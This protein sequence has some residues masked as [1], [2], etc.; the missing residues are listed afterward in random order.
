MLLDYY[1]L[2]YG[3][4]YNYYREY[5]KNIFKIWVYKN[6]V[7]IKESSEEGE[8][9]VF[10]YFKNLKIFFMFEEELRI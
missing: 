6:E 7:I 4:F 3:S 8:N 5:V 1:I 2:F 9:I 10:L